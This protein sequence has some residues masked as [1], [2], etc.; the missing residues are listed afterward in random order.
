MAT[1]KEF[2]A[3]LRAASKKAPAKVALATGKAVFDT[4][5]NAKVLA[6]VDTGH[7]MG[8]IEGEV[9]VTGTLIEGQV[10]AAASYA[11]YVERGTSVMA[12]Q[13]YMGPAF[14]KHSA[15]WVEAMKRIGAELT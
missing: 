13:P 10:T 12:P 14:E 2:A 5:S 4:T 7:L 9:V 15:K 8:T 11:K 1:P 3:Q 6:P